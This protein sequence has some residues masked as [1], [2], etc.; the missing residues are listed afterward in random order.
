MSSPP[1]TSQSNIAAFYRE[2]GEHSNIPLKPAN[3]WMSFKFFASVGSNISAN[4][5]AVPWKS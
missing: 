4:P 5:S 1:S 3:R 2:L